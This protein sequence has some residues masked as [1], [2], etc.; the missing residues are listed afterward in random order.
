MTKLDLNPSEFDDYYS[1]YINK[2]SDVTK[3]RK[4]FEI[5]E[6]TLIDFFKSIPE[7]KLTY[8]YQPEKWSV[9]EILQHLI[10]T[11]RIFM[12]RCFRIARRDTTA[13]AGYD[14]N[15]YIK[16]SE[17]NTKSL[18]SLLNEFTINRNHSIALL[19]SLTDEDLSFI[20]NANGG[21]M[22]A[23][24]AAFIILGHDIWHMEVIQNNYL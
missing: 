2:L 15:I 8:R 11:E 14:Q 10:D 7:E 16:P 17:A 6:I 21:A 9:K 22:S 4:G 1:R 18:D 19:N 3:L 24:A 20:G 13:L 5:G 23:R 12:Y